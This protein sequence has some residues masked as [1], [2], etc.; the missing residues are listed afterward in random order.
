MVHGAWY[1]VH[2]TWHM[3]HGTWYMVHGTCIMIA[4]KGKHCTVDQFS[5]SEIILNLFWWGAVPP[6]PS[7]GAVAPPAPCA[8][9]PDLQAVHSNARAILIEGKT[10]YLALPP[11]YVLGVLVLQNAKQAWNVVFDISEF[12][13]QISGN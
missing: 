10:I 9:S 4:S 13:L 7:L 6:L 11:A 3:A 1:M 5:S 8:A 2:G 12:R